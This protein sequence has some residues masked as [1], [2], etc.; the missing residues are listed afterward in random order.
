MASASVIAVVLTLNIAPETVT[1]RFPVMV[2]D[3]ICK[4]RVVALVTVP[5]FSVAPV[6]I[7][8]PV[9]MVGEVADLVVNDACE[10]YEVPALFVA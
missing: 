4:T 6:A 3:L 8:L 5:K 1:V 7:S 2:A 10:V 9:I